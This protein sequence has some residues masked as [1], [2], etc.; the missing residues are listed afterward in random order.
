MPGCRLGSLTRTERPC[1]RMTN[2]SPAELGLLAAGD[3]RLAAAADGD[4][5]LSWP[6]APVGRMLEPPPHPFRRN[7][8]MNNLPTAQPEPTRYAGPERRRHRVY[9][10]RN[11]EYHFRDG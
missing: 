6:S 3:S 2:R 8:T 9:V 7:E 4:C 1:F 11:T 5:P 10:T